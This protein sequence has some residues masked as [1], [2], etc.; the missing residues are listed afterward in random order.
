[1]AK[2]T[3]DHNAAN[4]WSEPIVTDAA[5]CANRGKALK[6]DIWHSGECSERSLA[7][8]TSCRGCKSDRI[9]MA[10]SQAFGALPHILVS[11]A[12]SL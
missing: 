9:S 7:S 5:R 2:L 10:K 11:D 6:V 3:F 8:A 4:V 12:A 1:M